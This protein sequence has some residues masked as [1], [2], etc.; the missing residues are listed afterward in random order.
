MRLISI[1]E[2]D[3]AN[4]KKPSMFLIFPYCSFKCDKDAGTHIC[5]NSALAH[6][7]SVGIDDQT[8]IK[9]YLE[10]PL[11]HAIVC[12]GLEPMD[13]F[14]ELFDFVRAFRAK[15]QDDIVIYTGYRYDEI[16]EKCQKLRDWNVIVKF[17][18][19]IPNREPVYDKILGV[20]LAS[21]NQFAI[22]LDD[23]LQ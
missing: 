19:F 21:N 8:I 14:D 2:Y 20:T 11:T 22:Q 6:E 23:L 1:V 13:S 3:I 18:R 9:R 5:Q 10:N 12:G 7:L 4:Y 17:G 15:S 16:M